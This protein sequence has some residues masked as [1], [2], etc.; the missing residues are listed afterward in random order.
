MYMCL[1]I[2]MYINWITLLYARNE[3]NIAKLAIL[4]GEKKDVFYGPE[5]GLS[6]MLHVNLRR[7]A[8]P[9]VARWSSLKASIIANWLMM[10][11]N[12][13]RFLKI[14]CLLDLFISD[15]V[16]LKSPT[17]IVFIY[18]EPSPQREPGITDPTEVGPQSQGNTWSQQDPC[19]LPLGLAPQRGTRT[20]LRPPHRAFCNHAARAVC[21]R[22]EPRGLLWQPFGSSW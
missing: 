21:L 13:I 6:W 9:V 5:H 22:A 8:Y 17:M 1:C 14:S 10:W 20:G 2:Y 16:V 19:V 3:H 12:S 11:L 7:N 4:E 18:I 15:K